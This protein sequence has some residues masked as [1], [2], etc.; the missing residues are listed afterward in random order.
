MREASDEGLAEGVR[1]WPVL[2]TVLRSG[3]RM[4]EAIRAMAGHGFE[5]W[6]PA[7]PLKHG[8]MPSLLAMADGVRRACEE[9]GTAV[10]ALGIYGNPLHPGELG[11]V[12]RRALREAME[13]APLMGTRVIGCFA[14][15]EPGR[16]VPDCMGRFQEVWA[17]LAEEA[18]ERGLVFAF[19]NC[20]QGGNWETGDWNLAHH[21]DAWA[22]MFA[23]VPLPSLALEWEPA[24]QMCQLIDPLAQ[25]RLWA[26]RVAHVHGKDAN[27]HRQVL[28]QHGISGPRRFAW[29]RNPGFGDCDWLEIMKILRGA[30]SSAAIDIEGFHDPVYRGERELEGQ[31]ASLAYLRACRRRLRSV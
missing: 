31:L 25:L 30:G 2:G 3:E 29:H 26:P 12:S 1:E 13:A 14:G 20:Q 10:S 16:P 27:I 11:K 24:H 17:P 6:Q 9:T 21:P 4:A 18:A 23:A 8:P 28:A 5:S 7:F 19:E 22:L 15:R